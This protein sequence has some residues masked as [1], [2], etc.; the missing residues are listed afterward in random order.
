MLGA[1]R[2]GGYVPH[3]TKLVLEVLSLA[4]MFVLHQ[5]SRHN[6]SD[7]RRQAA[8]PGDTLIPVSHLPTERRTLLY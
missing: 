4:N 1:K 3:R 8:A 5:H 2:P 7:H 6:R